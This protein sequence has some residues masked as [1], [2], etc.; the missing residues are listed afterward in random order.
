VG[1]QVIVHHPE[2]LG[3]VV[4]I[5]VDH[6]KGAVDEVLGGQHGVAGAPGLDPAFRHGVACGQLFQLLESVFHVHGLG[7]P[8]A[9]GGLEG[10]LDLVLDH[11]DHRLKAGPAC[12]VKGIIHDDLAVGAHRVD[13]LHT[14]VTAAHA[15]RHHDQ[16]RFVHNNILPTCGTLCR[17]SGC[18]LILPLYS[19]TAPG[20]RA[21]SSFGNFQ[22]AY[23]AIL[24]CQSIAF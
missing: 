2:R 12:I 16:Y 24:S 22:L 3:A 13:L 17:R 9:D 10:I 1:G 7:H 8:V 4:V 15:G 6:R 11:K 19:C 20:A 21:R 5:G 14:A 18:P 23:N